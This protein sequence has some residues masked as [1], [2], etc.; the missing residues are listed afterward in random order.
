MKSDLQQLSNLPL[1]LPVPW[2]DPN[3]VPPGQLAIYINDLERACAEQPYNASLRTCLGM[4]QGMNLDVYKSLD[5][6]ETATRLD[7]DHFWAQLK[8]AEMQYRLRALDCARK[9]TEK[10]VNLATNS[11]ELSIARNQL[12]E[13]RRLMREGTQKPAWTKPLG[14]P[15]LFLPLFLILVS[16]AYLWR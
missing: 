11:W 10:A 2:R 9:E 13:I 5:S 16:A 12:A 6:L 3:Q 15:A 14:K 8:F 1:P 7:P 4:A